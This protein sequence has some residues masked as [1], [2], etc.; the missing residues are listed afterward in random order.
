MAAGVWCAAGAPPIQGMLIGLGLLVISLV[1]FPWQVRLERPG[2]GRMAS[3]ADAVYLVRWT[4]WL[5]WLLTPLAVATL[6]GYIAIYVSARGRF[7]DAVLEPAEETMILVWGCTSAA[8][9]VV[10]GVV[11]LFRHQISRA[12]PDRPM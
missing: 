5:S 6:C 1:F 9:A 12:A 2:S 7:C 11:A 4:R 10:V 3:Y 8:T